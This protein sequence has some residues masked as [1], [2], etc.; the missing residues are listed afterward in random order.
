MEVAPTMPEL[1]SINGHTKSVRKV[2][3]YLEGTARSRVLATD[4]INVT[5]RLPP[6]GQTWS[7]NMDKTR[8]QAG[9][10]RAYK[11]KRP[12]TFMHYVISPDPL[13]E[14]D[15][16]TLRALAYDWAYSFFGDYEVAIV[17]HSDNENEVMHAHVIVNNTNFNDGHRLS[18]DLTDARVAKQNRELQHMAQALGLRAFSEDHESM[19]VGEMLDEGKGIGLGKHREAPR[20]DRDEAGSVHDPASSRPPRKPRR[21]RT[22]EQH[23]RRGMD[24]RDGYVSWKTEIQ[25]R[26]DVARA[27][28]IDESQF[29]RALA[30]MGIEV[31]ESRGGDYLFHHPLG[32]SKMVTGSRLGPVYSKTAINRGFELGYVR[33]L[34]R[35]KRPAASSVHGSPAVVLTDGQIARVASSM[36]ASTSHGVPSNVRAADLVRLLDYNAK[37]DITSVS[38]YGDG[39]E[40]RA[41]ARLA[42]R[43]GIFDASA[44]VEKTKQIRDDA[45]LIGRWLQE[46]RSAV[47]AG[48]GSFSA[49]SMEVHEA[50]QVRHD[51][52]VKRA[53][54]QSRG[55]QSH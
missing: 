5:D 32:G 47:G 7:Q 43:V 13:D 29:I 44:K 16:A 4:L 14:I 49:N 9:N 27:I 41:M 11:G 40:A 36:R 3:S 1:V 38:A 6:D 37:H 24:S 34:Q 55:A 51:S 53:Q 28:S 15:L 45:R 46:T 52:D 18:S 26:V 10:D 50:E 8:A 22:I 23:G 21:T 30:G 12:R 33:W 39:P 20:V 54:Q 25:D 17:Y 2:Q 42:S 31:T 35:A 48:G 19:T